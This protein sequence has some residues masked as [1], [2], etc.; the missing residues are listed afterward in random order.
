[1]TERRAPWGW[2]RHHASVLRTPVHRATRDRD[3]VLRPSSLAGLVLLALGLCLLACGNKPSR[4]NVILITLDTTRSDHLGCYGAQAHTPTLDSLAARGLRFTQVSTPVPLTAPAHAT[5]LTGL[6]PPGHGVRDN[7]IH[8]LAE[9]IPTLAEGL[10]QAG[11]ETAGFVSAYV[12]DRRFGFARG[13]SFY[14]DRFANE[15]PGSRTT[16]AVL[17][18]LPGRDPQKPLFLWVHFYDPH[19]PWTPSEPWRS[20]DL[21]SPYACEIAA[22]DAAL[23]QLLAGLRHAGVLENAVVIAVGDHGEGLG[24]HGETEH[25][26]FLYDEVLRVPLILCGSGVAL[27]GVVEDPGSLVDVAP[28][29][30]AMA[31]VEPPAGAEGHRLRPGQ[32]GRPGNPK[33][34][35]ERARRWEY[36][37]TLYPEHAFGHAP[38]YALRTPRWK[39]IQAPR[40]EL[41][42]LDQDPKE[43]RDLVSVEG[44]TARVL[45]IR[46]AQLRALMKPRTPSPSGLSAE[47]EERLRSLG[48]LAGTTTPRTRELPDPKEMLPYLGLLEDAKRALEQERWSEA[49]GLLRQVLRRNPENLVAWRQL[50]QSLERLGRHPEAVDALE[51]AVRL[52]PD[53]L[54]TRRLLALNCR[55]AANPERALAVYRT[56]ARDPNERWNAVQGAAGALVE[57]N[58]SEEALALLAGERDGPVGNRAR[59]MADAVDRYRKLR[60]AAVSGG[61][62]RERLTAAELAFQLGLFGACR[63]LVGFTAEDLSVEGAR[64]RL[65]G[66]LEGQLNRHAEAVRAFEEAASRLPRDAYVQRHL[67]PLQLQVGRPREAA[68]AARAAQRVDPGNPVDPYNEACALAL[69]GEAD[70]ALA[71]LARSLEQ[72]YEDPL[73]WYADPD[74]ESLQ[75]DP[76]FIALVEH[77]SR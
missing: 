77:A 27:G 51:E 2:P 72:G 67:A 62:D 53:N 24:D 1:M 31:G 55:L 34:R 30:C 14:E 32:L 12:L 68:E 19:T 17:R 23:G 8:I 36:A 44:D 66:S 61:T 38:L 7:G 73:R 49:E 48:Y 70:A 76:R 75:D 25:G 29:L 74:L 4:P 15:R 43:L 45:S 58:R 18:W 65:L 16:R 54:G 3:S 9:G 22:M 42:R 28:T 41:Y 20:L 5:I 63:R 71:A 56:L 46:L 52:D 10:R 21:P 37:E 11:Y 13:F 47:E 35:P 6:H 26:L 57:L 33:D 60:T 39:Y 59:E 69:L 40:P 64:L 50:G